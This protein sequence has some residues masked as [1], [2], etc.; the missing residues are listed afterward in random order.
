MKPATTPS[1]K[2]TYE[3]FLNFPDDGKRHEIID[4]EHFVTPSPN[5][6]H[7]TICMNLAVLAGTY[8][9]QHPIGAFFVALFDV[10]LSN[11]D[12]V[13]PDLLY[14]SRE[15]AE[16]LT[17]KHVRGAPD[18][19]VEIL[20]PG[21]RRTDE[22]TKRKR[23]ERFGVGEYWIV[24]PELETIKVYRRVEQSFTRVAELTLEQGDVLTTPLLPGFSVRLG[25]IFAVIF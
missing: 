6:K 20:S 9:R 10:V 16:V 5:T 17:D 14:I 3:D 25:E 15:R 21:T 22:V 4:G 7:Q 12:V 1:V 24:D 13:E 23:Y 19:V 11:L 18:L 2:F 8:L